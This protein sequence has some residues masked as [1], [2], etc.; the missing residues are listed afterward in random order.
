MR[1]YDSSDSALIYKNLNSFLRPT[2]TFIIMATLTNE[3]A[4]PQE[5][6]SDPIIAQAL[7]EETKPGVS[8]L[9]VCFSLPFLSRN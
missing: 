6:R 3:H 9:D 4:A 7:R 1:L 5:A 2:T 8:G